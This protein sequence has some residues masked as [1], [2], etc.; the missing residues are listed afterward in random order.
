MGPRSNNAILAHDLSVRR[1]NGEQ[2]IS[3]GERGRKLKRVYGGSGI[4]FTCRDRRAD[5]FTIDILYGVS[6]TER[7]QDRLPTGPC[8]KHISF[9]LTLPR[10]GRKLHEKG[11][12]LRSCSSKLHSF[13]RK[14]RSFLPK[15][16]NLL[17]K[18]Y[19]FVPKRARFDLKRARF[20]EKLRSFASISHNFSKK[21]T[22]NNE[23][24]C[25]YLLD[26][27]FLGGDLCGECTLDRLVALGHVDLTAD[28]VGGD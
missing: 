8:P 27:S 25:R 15:L 22:T 1:G 12:F 20:V 23:K 13:L 10:H 18:R 6:V 16:R 19:G 24:S 2:Q 11:N 21:L 5:N 17:Q 14:L 4:V 7:V 28:G 3:P 9:T 26:R